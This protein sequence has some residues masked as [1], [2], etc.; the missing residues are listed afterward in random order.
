MVLTLPPEGRTDYIERVCGG[1][2][3]LENK[4]REM[5]AQLEESDQFFEKR[6]GKNE[7]LLKEID[8]LIADQA[9]DDDYFEGKTIGRWEILELIGHGGMGRVYKVQRVDESGIKQTGALKIIHKSLL[10]PTHMERF[11]LEQHI[12]SGLQHPNISGFVDS[13]I[14]ADRVPYMVMEFVE[15]N[16]I[17]EYCN[18]QRLTIEQRLQLFITVCKAIQYAHKSLI[19]H[20]DLK[21]EN[22]LVTREGRIKILDFGIAKLLDPDLYENSAIETQPGMRMLSLEY[23]SPEQISGKVVTTSTDLYSLGVLLNKLLTGLHPFDLNKLTYKDVEQLLT[24]KDPLPASTRFQS[25]SDAEK[26]NQLATERKS[27]PQELV[28]FL[29]GDLDAIIYK[30]LH[31]DPERRYGSVEALITDLERYEKRLPV[32]ARPDTFGYRVR[33]FSQRHTN[34]IVVAAL[35]AVVLVGTVT[36]YTIRITA[37]RDRAEAAVIQANIEL[38][39]SQAIQNFLTGIFKTSDPYLSLGQNITALELLDE[40]AKRFERDLADQPL[41]KTAIMSTLGEVY[42]FLDEHEKADSLLTQALLFQKSRAEPD[43]QMTADALYRLGQLRYRQLIYD[44][45]IDYL[46]QALE[47]YDENERLD[48]NAKAGTQSLMGTIMHDMGDFSVADSLLRNAV[49]IRRELN[50]PTDLAISMNYLA[51][52]LN[53][54]GKFEEAEPIYKEVLDIQNRYLDPNDPAISYTTYS[55]AQMLW[56]MGDLEESELLFRKIV[57]ADKRIFGEDHIEVALN[58]NMLGIV[59]MDQGR[60]DEAEESFQEALDIQYENFGENHPDYTATLGNLASLYFHTEN[61]EKSLSAA[62]QVLSIDMELLDPDNPIVATGLTKLTAA[63]I[64]VGNIKEAENHLSTAFEIFRSIYPENHHRIASSK[65][66]QGMIA[67]K[68]EKFKTADSV[69]RQALEDLDYPERRERRIGEALYYL[70]RALIENNKIAEAEPLLVDAT[71]ILE[72]FFPPGHSLIAS[73]HSAL[74]QIS[75]SY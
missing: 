64:A 2:K 69:L 15:G 66:L 4:I 63:L 10:T 23:A 25:V 47:I 18:K 7:E 31:K 3:E 35:L 38:E 53:D 55:Y 29:K 71:E 44:E 58:L 59:L 62:R 34:A 36:M 68:Q 6:L 74:E 42:T 75:A 27:T 5:L 49:S 21:P 17:L 40:G 60:Y 9:F 26:K 61:Y 13:G 12:L 1:D 50:S 20:R 22:I 46:S 51:M 52:L 24:E 70:S 37:E 48:T 30:A 57:E 54:Q 28:N 8:Q 73:A 65:V 33:K 72:E 32:S 56:L 43:F 14:T 16:T 11:R 19:V 67:L 41:I 39:K 45:A